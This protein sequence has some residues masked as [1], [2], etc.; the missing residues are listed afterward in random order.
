[1][2]IKTNGFKVQKVNTYLTC[3]IVNRLL[4]IFISLMWNT[5]S[6]GVFVTDKH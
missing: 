3:L 5:R 4:V 6:S 1:M 2:S